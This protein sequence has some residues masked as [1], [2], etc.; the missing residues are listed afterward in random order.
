MGLGDK[1]GS[2]AVGLEADMVLYDIDHMSLMP[3]TNPVAYV[4]RCSAVL[5]VRLICTMMRTEWWCSAEHPRPFRAYGF[6]AG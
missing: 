4:T 1:Y 6:A 2:I 3:R 5:A